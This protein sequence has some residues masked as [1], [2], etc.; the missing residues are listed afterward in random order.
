MVE[1]TW[2]MAP[3]RVASVDSMVEARF[4]GENSNVLR[5]LTIVWAVMGTVDNTRMAFAQKEDVCT[6]QRCSPEEMV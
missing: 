2:A 6:C 5:L 3:T 1:M 4:G